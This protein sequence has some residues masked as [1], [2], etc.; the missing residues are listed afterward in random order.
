VLQRAFYLRH[1]EAVIT[2]VRLAAAVSAPLWVRRGPLTIAPTYSGGWLPRF[3][4]LFLSVRVPLH[5]ALSVASFA[6]TLSA[7]TYGRVGMRLAWASVDIVIMVWFER[8]SRAHFLARRQAAA[9]AAAARS[10]KSLK[11]E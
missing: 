7:G 10:A 9:V 1:R 2:T 6:L 3:P 4:L 5:T 11:A 8:S